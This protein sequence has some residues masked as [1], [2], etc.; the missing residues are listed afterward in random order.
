[1]GGK[2][3]RIAQCS[4]VKVTTNKA[5]PMQVDGEPCL[6]APSVITLGFHSKV[7]MLKREKKTPCTP[8][9]MRRGTRYGQK[10]SQ[11][12][13]TSL[14]IQLPVIVV[15]RADYDTYK[16]CFERLKD[17]G[18]VFIFENVESNEMTRKL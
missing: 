18:E 1:M 11:V 7:P 12:Q 3:E 2:G 8:N 4:R 13:S 14:I 17:T 5:I 9:L 15:G 16:D 10:D 6:L